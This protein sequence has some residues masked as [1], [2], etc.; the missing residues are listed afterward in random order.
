MPNVR[1]SP[2]T[3][4]PS[5][6]LAKTA[7]LF[8]VTLI[9]PALSIIQQTAQN[10]SANSSSFSPKVELVGFSWHRP[11]SRREHFQSCYHPLPT[12]STFSMPSSLL[13]GLKVKLVKGCSCRH[14]AFLNRQWFMDNL[15]G[16]TSFRVHLRLRVN[17]AALLCRNQRNYTQ[18]G[19]AVQES[20]NN[21]SSFLLKVQGERWVRVQ[22]DNT[23]QNSLYDRVL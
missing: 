4:F 18:V 1:R 20:G 6:S 19:D 10:S 22:V 12:I 8:C 13:S 2:W 15:L 23:A 14:C 9:E 7:P 16:F 5:S 21:I 3:H 17:P 11:T